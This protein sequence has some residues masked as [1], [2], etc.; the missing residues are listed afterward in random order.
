MPK[1]NLPPAFLFL[2][3]PW[4]DD[5]LNN[6]CLNFFSHQILLD[7]FVFQLRKFGDEKF[8]VLP[9]SSRRAQKKKGDRLMDDLTWMLG[10]L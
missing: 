3:C 10:G 1:P 4:M 5:H 7:F 9:T 8:F 2:L 6:S